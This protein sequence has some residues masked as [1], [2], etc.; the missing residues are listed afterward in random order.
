MATSSSAPLAPSTLTA[1]ICPMS[2][3]KTSRRMQMMV[4]VSKGWRST[5]CLLCYWPMLSPWGVGQA[6]W[7]ASRLCRGPACA[8]RKKAPR[9]GHCWTMAA[10]C[11]PPAQVHKR[12]HCHSILPVRKRQRHSH[13]KQQY[14]SL[15]NVWQCIW[16]STSILYRGFSSNMLC[17]CCVVGHSSVGQCCEVTHLSVDPVLTS[18]C[19]ALCC[20]QVKTPCHSCP[21]TKLQHMPTCQS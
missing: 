17:T 9:A 7:T 4:R 13:E 11:I 14:R 21:M 19:R 10:L 12:Q 8:S 15:G 6:A 3:G 1:R 18:T 20:V 2:V 16:H 5:P